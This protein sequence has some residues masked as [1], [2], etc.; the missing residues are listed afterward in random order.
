[1]TSLS[2]LPTYLC[3]P[4]TSSHIVDTA[5]LTTDTQCA[6]STLPYPLPVLGGVAMNY[7]VGRHRTECHWFP[8]STVLLLQWRL[9]Y[10][11]SLLECSPGICNEWFLYVVPSRN[12]SL[13]VWL[14]GV[15]TFRKSLRAWDCWHGLVSAWLCPT[16]VMIR[17]H[18]WVPSRLSPCITLVLNEDQ[19]CQSRIDVLVYHSLPWPLPLD[20]WCRTIGCHP[21]RI[22]SPNTQN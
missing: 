20:A 11:P 22:L 4:S 17:N 5:L 8:S 13:T 10:S 1:M 14:L 7:V 16:L 19:F 12:L 21:L 2:S 9:S 18:R 6:C 15:V 3:P